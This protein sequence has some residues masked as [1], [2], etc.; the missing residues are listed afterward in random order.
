MS[1]GKIWYEKL[2]YSYNP[3]T[4]KPGFFDD[5]II[6]YDD[7]V[8]M[9]IEKL[10]DSNMCFLEADFGKGKSTIL[11]YIINEFA[12]KNRIIHIS[13]NRSDRSLDYEKLLKNA[14]KGLGRM[15][16]VKAKNVI[17]IVDEVA[18]INMKDCRQIAEYYDQG[19]IQSV[20]FADVSM[21]DAR[22][23]DDIRE[24]ISKNIVK[25]NDI[26]DENA[27]ALVKSRLESKDLIDDDSV[28]KIFQKSKK[29]TRLFLASLEK[30]FKAAF[31][32]DQ[33]RV[34][35][36]NLEVLN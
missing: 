14:K 5:E 20:L 22:L 21:R 35:E 2:G 13:R 16:G 24:K 23:S 1:E 27:I 26:T 8:D 10:S 17:L 32:A 33:E 3:F 7:E 15:F 4:I 36:K 9:L 11:T 25:L 6:G 28:V 12:G 29:N 31:D 18:K 19:F 30:V 34:S